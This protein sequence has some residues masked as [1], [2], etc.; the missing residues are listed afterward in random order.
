[1]RH[2]MRVRFFFFETRCINQS[3]HIVLEG[4]GHVPQVPQWYDASVDAL[5]ERSVM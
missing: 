2:N 3:R 4:G 5:G 1:M